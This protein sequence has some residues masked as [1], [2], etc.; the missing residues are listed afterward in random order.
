M[1]PSNLGDADQERLAALCE[2]LLP[3]H[4]QLSLAH[5]V[6]LLNIAVE[7][8]LSVTG[9]AERIGAP[10]ASSSRYVSVL[11]GRYQGPGDKPPVPLITQEVSVDDPRR[12]ALF[13]SDHG[14]ELVLTILSALRADRTDTRGDVS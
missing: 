10:Q 5:L 6:S 11:L 7:P 9:L 14:K 1:K 8:G 2:A 13:L 12:R 3:L 4:D